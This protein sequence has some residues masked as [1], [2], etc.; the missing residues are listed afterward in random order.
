VV[1]DRLYL[2]YDARARA[3]FVEAPR[4]AVDAA[5]RHWPELKRTLP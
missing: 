3:D 1:G 5:R 4:R 2:F